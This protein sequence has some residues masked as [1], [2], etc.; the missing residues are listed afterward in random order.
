[1]DTRGLTLTARAFLRSRLAVTITLVA[2]IIGMS[3]VGLAGAVTTGLIYACVNNNS[4]TIKIVSATTTCA[5]N[6]I[7]LV[8]N[9][10]GIPG[11]TG[12]TGATG[13]TG[14]TGPTGATGD[15]GASGP[16]G[17]TGATGV[18]GP[19]GPTGAT[20]ATGAAGGN[21]ATGA[22]GPT[23]PKGDQGIQGPTGPSGSATPVLVTSN[24]LVGT[25]SFI[26]PAHA[27][28]TVSCPAGKH[29][30]SGGISDNT[31]SIDHSFPTSDLSG[32]RVLATNTD[33]IN[34]GFVAVYVICI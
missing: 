24:F 32:W 31:A 17:A 18:A 28:V 23:G 2:A 19:T 12:A 14:P 34:S 16:N 7:Q 8:W 22:T 29:V 20:G 25:G 3:T 15:T 9:A 4:G 6:E 21:G 30:A 10:Q 1:M 5:T 11:E 27:D 33:P 13:A 26:S